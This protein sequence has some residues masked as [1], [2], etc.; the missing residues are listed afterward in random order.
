M[1]KHVV[2]INKF[3]WLDLVN[4]TNEELQQIALDYGLHA[5]SVED[6]L[7]P[8][9]QPKYERIGD[10][11]FIILR[12][13]DEKCQPETNSVFNMTRK[14]AIFYGEKILITV[15]RC[16]IGF[17]NDL[18]EK[19]QAKANY[20]P[21]EQSTL[22]FD[23]IKRAIFSYAPAL[24][25]LEFSIEQFEDKIFS[26]DDTPAIIKEVHW[27]RARVSTIRR[28]FRQSYDALLKVDDFDDKSLPIIYDI[29]ERLERY[30]S[31]TDALKEASN[32]ILNTHLSLA[33]HRTNSVIRILTLF[34]AF[35]LPLTF[36]VGVYGMNFEYMPELYW[37]YG[38]ALVWLI[39]SGITVGI[40]LWFRKRRWL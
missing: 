13:Y 19:W 36:I 39:M 30:I 12:V 1:V 25:Q 31:L 34:S 23:L 5:T 29:Q 37:K 20:T 14:I 9:H 4:P 35:F 22:L 11:V 10:I 16:E 32:D 6:C 2:T 3:T 27:F 8:I 21:L 17:I 24:E 26:N 7:D 28:I 40:F 15:H 18:M 33:S 38:Y